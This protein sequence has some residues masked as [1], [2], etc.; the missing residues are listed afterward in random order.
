M[1]NLYIII[2]NTRDPNRLLQ[3]LQ[4]C[5]KAHFAMLPDCKETMFLE[6]YIK[7]LGRCL[8][9]FFSLTYDK[10][11]YNYELNLLEWQIAVKQKKGN[12]ESPLN[13]SV[14]ESLYYAYKHHCDTPDNFV[15]MSPATL[16]REHDISPKLY[17]KADIQVK[18]S[19][20]GWEDIDRLLLTKVTCFA[21]E[22]NY[23]VRTVI[24]YRFIFRTYLVIQSCKRIYI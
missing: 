18:A 2:K 15:M 24:L 10:S 21:H 14:L 7:L 22:S 9:F 3:K 20:S 23:F 4:N 19:C 6:A 8:Q 13:S 1:K 16:S 12:D 11:L 17:Q 5:Y